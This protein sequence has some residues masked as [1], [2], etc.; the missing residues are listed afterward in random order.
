MQLFTASNIVASVIQAAAVV[1]AVTFM[2]AVL[3]VRSPRI[4]L[5]AGRVLLIL[6]VVM[7]FALDRNLTAWCAKDGSTKSKVVNEILTKFLQEQGL[8]P[9]K[10]PRVEVRYD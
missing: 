3:R 7:P 10:S 1:A 2:L 6:A 9:H 8:K 4:Q 5:A